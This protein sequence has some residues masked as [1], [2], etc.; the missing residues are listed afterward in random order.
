MLR[1]VFRRPDP[2][3]DWESANALIEFVMR[4]DAKL[5]RV[6][7]LLEEEHGEADDG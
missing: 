4:I 5:D 3:F 1:G 6:L 2:P 7:A